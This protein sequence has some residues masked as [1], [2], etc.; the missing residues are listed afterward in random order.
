M[1][2]FGKSP[3]AIPPST[4]KAMDSDQIFKKSKKLLSD[5]WTKAD[6]WTK[7][8]SAEEPPPRSP[9]E[10][11]ENL[12]FW[13]QKLAAML[14]SF[15]EFANH[16]KEMGQEL[17]EMKD[18]LWANWQ[19]IFQTYGKS[20]RYFE[21]IQTILKLMGRYQIF[22]FQAASLS[23]EERHQR[24]EALHQQN[25]E[26]LAILCRKQGGA[27]VKAAQFMSCNAGGLPAIYSETLATLQDQADP[28][29]WEKMKPVLQE[30][31]GAEW[32]E[33]FRSIDPKPLATASIGQVHKAQMI[34]G[35]C[36]ALKIQIPGVADLIQADLKFFEAIAPLLNHQI[37]ALDMEQI[38]RELSKSILKELDYFHEAS[39]LT[40]FFS[41]YEQQQWE[42]PILLKDLLTAQTLGMY[43]IEGQPIR[44]FLEDVPSAAE[45]VL[46]ELVH[47]FLK[48]IFINGLF[49]AD[50]HPGNFFVTPQGKIA[51]LDFGAV[52]ELAPKEALAYRNLLMALLFHQFENLESLLAKAGFLTPHPEK[53]KILL[54]QKHTEAYNELTKMQFYLEAMRQA[55]VEVPNNFILMARVLIVIGGLLQQ[56]QVKLD[57]SA[58][59][60]TL[61]SA[62]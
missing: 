3:Q 47:S 56:H 61:M 37:E 11:E 2:V 25:A 8:L 22:K 35:P 51:L 33:R 62:K 1:H 15:Q 9:S 30:A 40:Q 6:E 57:L 59:A 20:G 43:F 45:A 27:W 48:Q 46:Q 7:E 10:S 53:L 34:Y 26:E 38:V 60:L 55:E 19:T 44:Q 58:V 21:A 32:Q 14:G 18:Q 12:S 54:V 24:E 52:A 36:V 13:Q 39:N 42:Y 17:W 4:N 23:P 50:P 41:C 28:I 5:A 29:P 31:L 49:H 16:P